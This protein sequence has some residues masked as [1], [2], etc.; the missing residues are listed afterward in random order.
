MSLNIR[1]ITVKGLR[2]DIELL[3]VIKFRLFSI[4]ITEI[5]GD[6]KRFGAFSVIA[7]R[8]QRTQGQRKLKL[9]YK[10]YCHNQKDCINYNILRSY[11]LSVNF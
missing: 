7:K 3:A 10:V 5:E 2:L 6:I 1:P 8:I 11:V 9:I 4:I